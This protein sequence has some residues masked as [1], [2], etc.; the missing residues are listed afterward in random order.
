M[1]RFGN[2]SLLP[3]LAVFFT[4][5]LSS[6]L[7]TLYFVSSSKLIQWLLLI[8]VA[9]GVYFAI[10]RLLEFIFKEK[11]TY[12]DQVRSIFYNEILH[13]GYNPCLLI[14]VND[15][16]V[17][18]MN[19]SASK[20]LT[21]NKNQSVSLLTDIFVE[22]DSEALIEWIQ[23][24]KTQNNYSTQITNVRIKDRHG[25]L[26]PKV[27]KVTAMPIKTFDNEMVIIKIEPKSRVLNVANESYHLLKNIDITR[28]A[29][30]TAYW[31]L[32]IDSNLLFFSSLVA[33]LLGLD[34]TLSSPM[35][36]KDLEE[37]ADCAVFKFAEQMFA[38]EPGKHSFHSQ[39]MI[40]DRSGNQKFVVMQAHYYET[41]KVILGTLY[42]MTSIKTTEIKLRQREQQMNQL[43]DS[44]PESI[45]VLQ[46]SKVVFLNRAAVKLF[47]FSDIS[48]AN[49]MRLSE[50]VSDND[51]SLLRDRIKYML[52]GKKRSYGFTSFRLRK[53]TGEFFDAE[54]AV[55]LIIYEAV[56]S[57]QFVIRDLTE[58]LRVKNALAKANFRLSALSSKTLQLIEAERKQIAGELHDDVGQ[59]LTAILLATK[60]VSRRLEEKALL[61]K[62]SD[63][64]L[65][66]SQSLDTVRNLSLLLR[67]AQLDSLGFSPAIKWQMDKLLSIDDIHYEIDDAGFRE[68]KD[69]Q[70]EIVGFRIVQESLTNIVKHAKR[71]L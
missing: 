58:V 62:V 13:Q 41:D 7:F 22:S 12:N 19:Y 46:K 33:E 44:I 49:D 32:E 3:H 29:A 5:V 54:V 60:W 66:A 1:K 40:I 63:I 48:D 21:I 16:K 39:K 57:I 4:V 55:N 36:L 68:L 47:A 31:E 23:S 45:L 59:S 70:A 67:P 56:E 8:F 37:V 14:S 10:D 27:S 24:I 69:K 52:A 18:E 17:V 15:L 30:G 42:D 61:E 2:R 65:I 50:F 6:G 35:L 25:K 26:I 28:H 64:H 51:K 71:N 53:S 38:G 43:I 20:A 11:E 34:N 9:A